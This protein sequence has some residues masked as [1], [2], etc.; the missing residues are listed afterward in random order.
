MF[1]TLIAL[2]VMAGGVALWRFLRRRLGRLEALVILKDTP[3]LSRTRGEIDRELWDQKAA[4][5]RASQAVLEVQPSIDLAGKPIPAQRDLPDPP[6]EV[7]PP[8]AP[9]K[10]SAML[11]AT[12][13]VKALAVLAL[14]GLSALA[15]T[16]PA[17]VPWHH[18]C[19]ACGKSL[20]VGI[21]CY[22]EGK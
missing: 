4:L 10:S 6:S 19:R 1:Q 22:C 17:P 14:L 11:A 20:D 16:R 8:A 2:L 12:G 15:C 21:T 18:H 5:D 7:E 13:P 3:K 9:T